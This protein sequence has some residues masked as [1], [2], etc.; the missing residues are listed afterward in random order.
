[1]KSDKCVSSDYP[2]PLITS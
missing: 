1:L 2:Q